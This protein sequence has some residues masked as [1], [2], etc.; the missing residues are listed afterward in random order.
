MHQNHKN[1]CAVLDISGKN[2]YRTRCLGLTI[3]SDFKFS[4]HVSYISVSFARKLNP[5]KSM[6]FLAKPM[7]QDF[8]SKVGLILPLCYLWNPI[9]WGSC[10][11]TLF[12]R[13]EEMHA[14]GL[15]KRFTEF[16]GPLKPVSF[17]PCKAGWKSA[18]CHYKHISW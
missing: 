17:Y 12:D 11:V 6:Q 9:V 3:D 2:G 10:N 5:L 16:T 14:L 8:Y 15:P 1:I 13:M 7:L 4:E 18:G